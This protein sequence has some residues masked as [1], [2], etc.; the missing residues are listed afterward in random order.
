MAFF[1]KLLSIVSLF[2]FFN[3]AHASTPAH[4]IEKLRTEWAVA[5][6]RT[7]KNKQ[8]PSF[9][10]LIHEAKML[11]EKHPHDP[12][13]LVW[14]GTILGSYG[15]TKGGLTA[16]PDVKKAR[17]LLEEAIQMDSN[18]EQG[19]AHAVLGALYARVPSWPI[20]FGDKRKA[21]M[22][23][24]KAVELDPQGSDANYYLGDFLVDNNEYE[25][26]R[27]HLELAQ[28]ASIRPDHEIQDRGRKG[29]IAVSL[30]KLHRLG[31]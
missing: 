23:L 19:F 21:R 30:N 3:M 8:L 10:K 2:A 29:E 7:P 11:D 6:F 28:H 14:Y 31:H 22:H 5:K 4:D 12:K 20:A 15:A 16:L 9:E 17:A 1:S 13:T 24:E 18:V 26:A 25:A 27:R